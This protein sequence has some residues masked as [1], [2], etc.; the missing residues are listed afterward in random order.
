VVRR[1]ADGDT[2]V[3][4]SGP[5][6]RLLGID[7]P[8]IGEHPL[9]EQALLALEGLVLGRHVRLQRGRPDRDRYDRFLRYVFVKRGERDGRELFVNAELVR[10]G[11]AEVYRRAETDRRL[12][13]I[14]SAQE[15]ARRAGRGMWER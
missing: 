1:V 12:R 4:E 3:L 15:E 14:I 11:L 9:A 2:F 10:M 13:E 7:A 6:V 5:R 8:E